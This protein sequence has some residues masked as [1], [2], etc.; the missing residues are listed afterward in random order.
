M[1]K[2]IQNKYILAFIGAL[3]LYIS[4]PPMSFPFLI[5][6]ALVPVL[7]IEDSFHQ[8]PRK[9]GSAKLLGYLYILFLIWNILTTWWVFNA[10]KE[11]VFAITL[12]SLFMCIPILLFHKTRKK[13]ST[14]IAYISLVCYWLAFE[15]LHLRWDISWPWLT[16]G[17]VFAKWPSVIQW[18]EYTGVMGGTVWIWVVNILVAKLVLD[19]TKSDKVET[20]NY[21]KRSATID[22]VILIPI[23]VSLI[24][25]K[26]YNQ[27]DKHIEVVIV[28]PNLDPYTEKFNGLPADEQLSRMLSLAEKSIDSNTKVLML[29][30]T[31]ITSFADEALLDMNEEVK[32]LQQFLQKYPNLEVL[33]GISTYKIYNP[34]EEPSTTAR[35]QPNNVYVDYYNT[36]IYIT[37]NKPIQIYHKSKLVPGV[38]KMPF[39]VLLKFLEKYAIDNGGISGSL[40]VDDEPS[41]LKG[42]V[43]NAAPVICYE[44][45]YGDYVRQYIQKGADYIGIITNDGW[46]G[47]TDG[48]KQHLDYGTIRAIETRRSIARCANTG[49]S[50]LIDEKGDI[51][52]QTEWWKP[53]ILKGSI[54]INN[55]ITFY[56]IA[57][58]Y[59]SILGV[60]IAFVFLSLT[61]IKKAKG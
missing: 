47:N 20:Q 55:K 40:G 32:M 9:Y 39:P 48:Y 18:Y 16:L 25:Y 4:W 24:I 37:N 26:N 59:I 30:E 6:I 8:Q 2:I 27:S 22:I 36:A 1:Q 5:F 29:P 11:A 43:A 19:V 35:L 41:I 46:W 10:A 17:N 42:T 7:L 50:A 3:L 60:L 38:E 33:T 31:A 14:T 54:T 45:I 21:F 58:D 12:N 15:H 49:I 44:S 13:Y 61:L 28:Q 53:C 51:Y 23:I 56:T 34:N 52:D 57:G